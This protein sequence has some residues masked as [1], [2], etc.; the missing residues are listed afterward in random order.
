MVAVVSSQHFLLNSLLFLV[1]Q[2]FLMD[3]S[4][5]T[6]LF[7]SRQTIL[8]MVI[9]VADTNTESAS[10]KLKVKRNTFLN[11]GAKIE[12]IHELILKQFI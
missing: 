8:N 10:N 11:M 3:S 5:T 2:Q 1:G 12:F 6:V 4:V 9:S 7:F